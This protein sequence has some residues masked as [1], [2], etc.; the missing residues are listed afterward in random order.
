MVIFT[1]M[2]VDVETESENLN[3]RMVYR[4]GKHP[5]YAIPIYK[6]LPYCDISHVYEHVHVHCTT[7]AL[8]A[9]YIIN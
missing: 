3:F 4:I 9:L 1:L 2:S 8:Y 5:I 7:Y 6:V